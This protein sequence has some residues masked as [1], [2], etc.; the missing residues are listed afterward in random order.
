MYENNFSCY[1]L[2]VSIDDMNCSYSLKIS[3]MVK[4][5]SYGIRIYFELKV[6]KFG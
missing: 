1:V 2:W 4:I 3:F 5:Y 6:E